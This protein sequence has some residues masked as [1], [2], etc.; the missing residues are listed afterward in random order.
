MKD[1]PKIKE[2]QEFYDLLI[3]DDGTCEV[4]TWVCRTIRGGKY[5]FIL[6]NAF[7]WVK[8]SKKHH[9][10]GWAKT[11]RPDDRY[12]YNPNAFIK[13]DFKLHKTKLEAWKSEDTEDMSWLADDDNDPAIVRARNTIKRKITELSK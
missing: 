6:K 10:W 1:A 11:I 5:T 2:G 13:Q 9:D 8:Q 7:T 12:T 4:R 3:Y